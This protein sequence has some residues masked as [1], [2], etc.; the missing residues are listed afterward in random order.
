VILNKYQNFSYYS[1]LLPIKI[2]QLFHWS[3]SIPFSTLECWYKCFQSITLLR[4]QNKLHFQTICNSAQ[5]YFCNFN[6]ASCLNTSSGVKTFLNDC[7]IHMYVCK[8]ILAYDTTSCNFTVIFVFSV[9]WL[10]W[11]AHNKFLGWTKA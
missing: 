7:N 4:L 6:K 2:V 10:W 11:V 5:N 8:L 3:N 9:C 1:K